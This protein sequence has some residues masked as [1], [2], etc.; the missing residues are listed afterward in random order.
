MNAPRAL[1]KLKGIYVLIGDPNSLFVSALTLEEEVV[2]SMKDS[3]LLPLAIYLGSLSGH[4]YHP[5]DH[6]ELLHPK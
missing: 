6:V 2:P 4:T 3:H 5:K 1:V